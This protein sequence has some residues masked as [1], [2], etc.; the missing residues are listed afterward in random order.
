MGT[1]E[2]H[3]FPPSDP[4]DYDI[5]VTLENEAGGSTAEKNARDADSITLN[6]CAIF[7]DSVILKGVAQDLKFFET[8][9]FL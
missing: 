2:R 9:R 8:I 6:V 7:E 4:F 5:V 3:Q 1:L